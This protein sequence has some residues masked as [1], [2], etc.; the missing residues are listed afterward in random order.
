VKP[1]IELA[2]KAGISVNKG[3]IVNNKMQT[4]LPDIYAAGDCA[5]YNGMVWGIVPGGLRAIEIA[6]LNISG[7]DKTFITLKQL[8]QHVQVI[9]QDPYESLNPRS[10]ILDIVAEPLD[11]HHLVSSNQQRTSRVITALEEVGLRP[12]Q[13]YLLRYP[14]ELSGGQR[15]R[16]VIA[17]AMVL[18]PE[19]LLADEPVSMLDVSIRRE[20]F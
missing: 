9:F 4:N 1:N 18:E 12:A 6:A 10:T 15:Q 3:I 16:V 13:D 5:E 7:K 14:H 2:R 19:L 20:L 17:G 11:V 8:R